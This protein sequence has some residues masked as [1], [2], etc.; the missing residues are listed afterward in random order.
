MFQVDKVQDLYGYKAVFAEQDAQASQMAAA[1]SLDIICKT[2]WY[3]WISVHDAPRLLGLPM[4]IRILHVN[5]HKVG[6]LYGHH[7]G[8]SL[9]ERS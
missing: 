7:G 8:P 2:S 3:E 5:D 9:E 1:N 4:W 6:I